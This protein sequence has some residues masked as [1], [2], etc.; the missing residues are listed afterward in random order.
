MQGGQMPM[1]GHEAHGGMMGGMQGRIMGQMSMM[2][3]FSKLPPN[4]LEAV[5][6]SMMIPNHDGAIL[7]ASLSGLRTPASRL[8]PSLAKHG[9]YLATWHAGRMS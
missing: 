5:F 1:G 8:L 3:D 2:A 4:R 9:T 6:M 7:S